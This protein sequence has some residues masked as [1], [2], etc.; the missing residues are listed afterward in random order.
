M[1]ED[2]YWWYIV[3]SRAGATDYW[4]MVNIYGKEDRFPFY[5]AYSKADIDLFNFLFDEL[6]QP[7]LNRSGNFSKTTKDK[8]R[9]KITGISKD[10]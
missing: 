8:W 2:K 1:E 10:L 4:K 6:V 9:T 5:K 7:K 3:D